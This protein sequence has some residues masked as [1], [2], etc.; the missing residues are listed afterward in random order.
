MGRS[1]RK[2]GF[3]VGIGA[4][5]A[6]ADKAYPKEELDIERKVVKFRIE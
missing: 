2:S 6:E 4:E 1:Y 5:E 3:E